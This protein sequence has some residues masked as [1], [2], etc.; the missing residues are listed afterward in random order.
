LLKSM[1]P[2]A[3]SRWMKIYEKLQYENFT[4]SG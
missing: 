2:I 1:I 4:Q 3:F